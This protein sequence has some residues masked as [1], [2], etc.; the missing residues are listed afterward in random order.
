MGA[1]LSKGCKKQRQVNDV[2]PRNTMAK[3][4]SAASHLKTNDVVFELVV[5]G[6]VIGKRILE[7]G[8]GHGYMAQQLGLHIETQGGE[9]PRIL[10][11]CDSFPEYFEY[12]GIDC[13]RLHFYDELPFEEMSFDMVYAIEVIEH[14]ENPIA[15][16]REAHRVLMPGGLFIFTTPNILNANSRIDYLFSGFFELFGL[17]SYDSKDAGNVAGHCMP[18]NYYYLDYFMRKTGFARTEVHIDRIK[19]SAVFYSLFLYPLIRLV[20]CIKRWK[21]RRG[22]PSVYEKSASAFQT[23]NSFLL[24]TSRSVIMVGHKEDEAIHT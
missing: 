22:M 21:Y 15:L 2:H 9:P 5:R 6:G 7:V 24:L 18:L 3:P 23:M 1:G 16:I 12:D 19:R 11:A 14:L 13:Q 10:Y 4:I 17:L 20:H 8:A